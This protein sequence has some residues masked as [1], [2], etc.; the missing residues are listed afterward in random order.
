MRKS[1]FHKFFG[2]SITILMIA[3]I[4]LGTVMLGFAGNFWLGEKRTLLT[5]EARTVSSQMSDM[6]GTL[7]YDRYMDKIV[8]TLTQMSGSEVLIASSDGSIIY[9]GSSRNNYVGRVIPSEIMEVA[10]QQD[11]VEMG[12][13]QGTLE[14]DSYLVGVPISH[15]LGS[16]GVVFAITPSAG[17]TSYLMD[18]LKLFVLAALI[19]IVLVF[20]AIYLLTSNMVRPIREMAEAARCMARG[21][22][23]HYIRVNN[24]EDEVGELAVAFNNMTKSIAAGEQM[25]RG[26]IANVSHELKTPMTTISGF[27][28][29]ILD[30]TICEK[31]QKLYLEIV[32]G[33]VKRLARLVVSMLSL[34]KLEAGEMTIRPAPLKLNE[35]L[36]N[37]LFSFDRRIEEKRLDIV[38]LDTIDTLEINADHDLMHQAIY[39]LVDN[40]VKYTP[41]N[42]TIWFRGGEENGQVTMVIRNSGKGIQKNEL[43]HVFDRFYKVDKS[44]GTDKMGAGLGLYLVKTILSLHNGQITVSSAEG[45]YTEFSFV[46]K[47]SPKKLTD[48]GEDIPRREKESKERRENRESKEMN[49]APQPDVSEHF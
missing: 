40:A 25:R 10:L 37:V 48:V 18:M 44:R 19:V 7:G 26:F 33:E 24:R 27:I 39:N 45:Q 11:Y 3:M 13:L 38:G 35:L 15:A 9:S 42:G 28:D 2:I 31:E 36:V 34:S 14:Q 4:V 16:V 46:L 5:N 47:A 1:L 32:S 22:F 29:G 20:I 8:E 23:S 41:E 6:L 12:T 21:D 17:M 30:G 43:P 49:Q